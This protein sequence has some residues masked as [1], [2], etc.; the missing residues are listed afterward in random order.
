MNDRLCLFDVEKP[1]SG[2]LLVGDEDFPMLR[3]NVAHDYVF[4]EALTTDRRSSES[5]QRLKLLKFVLKK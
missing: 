2:Y 1:V 4:N 5:G 3:D